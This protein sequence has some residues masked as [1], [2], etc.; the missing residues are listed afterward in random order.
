ML[1]INYLHH[2][3]I[4]LLVSV[5]SG[6]GF[7]LRGSLDMS[8]EI[9][10]L[11][12]QENS[13]IALARELKLL[14]ATNNI[15]VIDKLIRSNSQLALTSENK[16]RRVLTVD[17]DGRAREYLLSYTVNFTIHFNQPEKQQLKE[18]IS[19]SR[20]LLFNTDA[21]LAVTNESE[22]LYKDMQRNAARLILLKLQAHAR[23]NFNLNSASSQPEN[24]SK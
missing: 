2:L 22:V 15:S 21:V 12:L 9:S 8:E 20:S 24:K 6:C 11:Y 4:I 10:P 17:G 14:L 3:K 7:Q 5:I 16:S 1:S 13:A 23:K 19:M 18:S